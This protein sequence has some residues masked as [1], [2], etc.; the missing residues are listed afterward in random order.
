M[1]IALLSRMS[2]CSMDGFDDVESNRPR[3]LASTSIFQLVVSLHFIFALFLLIL[4]LV[5]HSVGVLS[6]SFITLLLL[7]SATAFIG[8]SALSYNSLKLR[9]AYI[10]LNVLTSIAAIS[11]AFY[12]FI[13]PN[14][15]ESYKAF[16]LIFLFIL[17]FGMAGIAAFLGH[18]PLP[19]FCRR[20]QVLVMLSSLPSESQ[21]QVIKRNASDR[22]HESKS[23]IAKKKRRVKSEGKISSKEST[24]KTSPTATSGT[25]SDNRTTRNPSNTTAKSRKVMREVGSNESV[26]GNASEDASKRNL[27]PN[28]KRSSSDSTLNNATRNNTQGDGSTQSVLSS[29]AS[30][31]S[32]IPTG[33]GRF[34]SDASKRHLPPNR[35]RSSSD[36]TLNNAT[37]NNTQGDGSTQSVLSSLASSLSMIP[38]GIGRFISGFFL[39]E[40]K[41]MTDTNHSTSS[42]NKHN[43]GIFTSVTKVCEIISIMH[44]FFKY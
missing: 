21:V 27:P 33:I 10:L 28:R 15:Q 34:I 25:S 29:L 4:L 11:W 35:K 40:M 23:S 18:K 39:S 22:I 32:M 41:S 7:E 12:L 17:Q 6:P 37:R 2:S 14:D 42:D 19:N 9:L 16:I 31:L 5:G 30:S 38:T 26:Y 24:Q 43:D 3:Q 13:I 44:N 8:L 20:S 36:S 1:T